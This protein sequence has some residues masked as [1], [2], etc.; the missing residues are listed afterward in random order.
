MARNIQPGTA[1][2]DDA[3]VVDAIER[4]AQEAFTAAPPKSLQ[5][6]VNFLVK[7]L[8]TTKAVAAELGISQRSVER[9]RKGQRKNPP[10]NIAARIETAVRARWQPRIRQRAKK[11]AATSTGITIETRATFGYRAPVGTTDEGRQRRLTIH[12]PAH[13]ARRLFDAQQGI[14]D[15]TPNEVIADG[16]KEIYFQDGGHRAQ[17]LEVEF[18]GIDY[19]DVSY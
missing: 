15:Q 11:R 13:Y 3:L 16:I 8:K 1:D 6:Q 12:L 18:T 4:T 14:G 2:A 5:A 9:Y 19:I 10:K 7:Q 17:D